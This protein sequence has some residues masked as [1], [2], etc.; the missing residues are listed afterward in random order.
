MICNGCGATYKRQEYNCPYCGRENEKMTAKRQ[1]NELNKIYSKAHDAMLE[2]E[3]N[4]NKFTKKAIV[5]MVAVAAV[6]FVVAVVA[7][8]LSGPLSMNEYEKQQANV[9]KLEDMC[10]RKDYKAMGELLD[11]LKDSYKSNYDKYTMMQDIVEDVEYC[12]KDVKN[13]SVDGVEA[14][15]VNKKLCYDFYFLYVA[16]DSIER[17]EDKAFASEEGEFIEEYRKK[18]YDLFSDTYKIT[19]EEIEEWAKVNVREP[20]EYSGLADM[21]YERIMKN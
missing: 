12:E 4:A 1:Q 5:I 2:P 16:L 14:D 18:V 17:F 13:L 3:R 6:V 10:D 7:I 8:L 15:V 21:S 20:E 11:K 9:A 19:E